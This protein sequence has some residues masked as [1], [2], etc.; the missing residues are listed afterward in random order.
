MSSIPLSLKM[1]SFTLIKFTIIFVK[2][3]YLVIFQAASEMCASDEFYL[4]PVLSYFYWFYFRKIL[5]LIICMATNRNAV[6][7]FFFS[8]SC[9]NASFKDPN[10]KKKTW[11][12]VDTIVP[13]FY[14]IY[15]LCSSTKASIIIPHKNL[16]YLKVRNCRAISVDLFEQ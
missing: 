15:F 10:T 16:E 6:V 4:M 11:V 12:R 3:S 8:F 1:W 7:N 2:T 13:T 14:F 5:N 9:S